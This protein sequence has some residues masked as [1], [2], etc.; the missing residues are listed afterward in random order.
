MLLRCKTSGGHRC[1][2]AT[3]KGF[4]NKQNGVGGSPEEQQTG[5]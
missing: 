4:A 3:Q 1:R 2:I 5:K